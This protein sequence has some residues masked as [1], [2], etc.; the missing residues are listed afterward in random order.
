M[1]AWV[2]AEEELEALLLEGLNSGPPIK[3]NLM[4]RHQE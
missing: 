3:A 1:F 2:Y 4:A